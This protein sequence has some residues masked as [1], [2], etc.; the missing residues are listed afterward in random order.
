MYGP[1]PARHASCIGCRFRFNFCSVRTETPAGCPADPRDPPENVGGVEMGS[2]SRVARRDPGNNT[3]E[4]L[5]VNLDITKLA[6]VESWLCRGT[7]STHFLYTGI[8][9]PGSE[10]L[11]P[12]K[13]FAGTMRY[14]IA[15]FYC[16]YPTLD[17]E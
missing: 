17:V 1:V 9:L 14:I 16:T 10:D 7:F 13:G 5:E 15:R 12:S 3:C 8:A 2:K 11:A 6:A 4:L